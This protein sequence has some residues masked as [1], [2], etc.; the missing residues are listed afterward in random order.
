MIQ[1]AYSLEEL[2][3][4]RCVLITG[5]PSFVAIQLL[6]RI[7]EKEPDTHVHLIVRGDRIVKT[8]E[9]IERAPTGHDRVTIHRGTV[10]DPNFGLHDHVFEQL[11]E[12]VTDF[13]HLSSMHHL[14]AA[15]QQVEEVNILGTRVALAAAAKFKN[16]HRFHYYSTAFVCGARE[17]VILENDLEQGQ[18]FRSTYERTRLTAELDVR[19]A[20]KDLPISVYRA[21]LVVGDSRSGEIY[22]LDGPWIF[23]QAIARNPERL[24]T[25]LPSA[26]HN[27]F[28]VVPVDFVAH[29]MHA[30]SLRPD[31]EGYT[32]HLADP[33]PVSQASAFR[34][35]RRH[36]EEGP[37]LTSFGG[38]LRDRLLHLRFFEKRTKQGRPFLNELDNLAIFNTAHTLK[39]LRGT[40]IY[41]PYFPDYVATLVQF[42]HEEGAFLQKD[43]KNAKRWLR[44]KNKEPLDA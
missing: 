7:L 44:V 38:R 26:I 24:P 33:A 36:I 10:I 6:W 34:L 4:E 9:F 41:C 29:A 1:G 31:T 39:A 32:F 42:A 11:C 23:I 19:R 30:I 16:L 13:Y 28:N 3:R 14:G 8:E 17:G 35:L 12:Q 25:L 22:W 40:D 18:T 27:P 5:A 15:K 20:M 43:K 2:V 21:S 37:V